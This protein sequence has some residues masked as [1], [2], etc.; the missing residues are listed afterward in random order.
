MEIRS[1]TDTVLF[2]SSLL[3]IKDALIE[4][5]SKRADLSGADL[6]GAKNAE[7]HIQN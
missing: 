1:V 6:S 7:L 4:A 3:T 5:V 2:V